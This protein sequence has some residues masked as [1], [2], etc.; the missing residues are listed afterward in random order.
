MYA[1]RLGKGAAKA[2]ALAKNGKAGEAVSRAAEEDITD[3][4]FSQEL[5]MESSGL[6]SKQAYEK[7]A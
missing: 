7:F 3:Q 1:E 4:L 5:E 6:D 2:A